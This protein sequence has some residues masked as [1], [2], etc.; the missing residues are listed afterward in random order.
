M[1]RDL[2]GAQPQ[3]PRGGAERHVHGAGRVQVK[4]GSVAERH[5]AQLAGGAAVVGG[6]IQRIGAPRGP[7]QRTGR[8][9]QRQG[10]EHGAAARRRGPVQ[11]RH[12]QRGRHQAEA[13]ADARARCQACSCSALLE[14]HCSQA[15]RSDGLARPEP[16]SIIQ[17]AACRATLR[18]TSGSSPVPPP[19]RSCHRQD[20]L[21]VSA[22]DVAVDGAR[23]DIQARG[24]LAVAQ[25]FELRQQKASRTGPGRP[26]SISSISCSASRISSRCSTDGASAGGMTASASR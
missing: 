19:A 24:D 13:L 9:G 8:R 18:S 11:R 22:R 3:Q 2:A 26:D 1:Q 7:G 20:A 6:P 25:A 5:F 17:R 14:R 4:T 21:L 16:S 23:R 10:L 15:S 12:A